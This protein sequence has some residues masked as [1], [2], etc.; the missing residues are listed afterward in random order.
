MLTGRTPRS[1]KVLRRA[2]GEGHVGLLASLR[3]VLV[4][5]REDALLASLRHADCREERAK[6]FDN[7]LKKL[8]AARFTSMLANWL[9][10]IGIAR[11]A[12]EN[13]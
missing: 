3:G 6:Y 10:D 7:Y 4:S 8:I 12:E 9:S 11:R 13:V 5:E 1:E 2:R